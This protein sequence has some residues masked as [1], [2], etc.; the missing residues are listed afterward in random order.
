MG[1]SGKGV[2]VVGA[3]AGIGRAVVAE[4]TIRVFEGLIPNKTVSIETVSLRSPAPLTGS[5]DTMIATVT[6]GD[7]RRDAR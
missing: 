3:S 1:L 6:A 4:V 5:A 2:L 7:P